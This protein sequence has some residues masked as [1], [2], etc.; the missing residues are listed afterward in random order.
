VAAALAAW[1]SPDAGD[2]HEA[3][4]TKRLD[5]LTTKVIW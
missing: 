4:M 1:L 5:R 3:A 2:Q